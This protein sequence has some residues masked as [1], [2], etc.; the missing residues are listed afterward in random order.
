MRDDRSGLGY[1][2]AR[3]GSDCHEDPV[4][5]THHAARLTVRQSGRAASLPRFGSILPNAFSQGTP[6]AVGERWRPCLAS[7]PSP[8]SMRVCV[9]GRHRDGK[10][11]RRY[12]E[13][14]QARHVRRD[15][16]RSSVNEFTL[17]I[18]VDRVSALEMPARPSRQ[19][20]Q[21]EGHGCLGSNRPQYYVCC[22]KKLADL[23][24]TCALLAIPL[25]ASN[26]EASMLWN[27]ERARDLS[28]TI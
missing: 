3:A 12:P 8:V 16:T 24:V 14:G 21:V 6:A 15:E 9:C 4:A 22:M 27:M 20:M 17:D 11:R 13:C 18:V 25:T 10:Y 19:W 26:A 28:G 23:L 7:G 5:R 1:S 2:G